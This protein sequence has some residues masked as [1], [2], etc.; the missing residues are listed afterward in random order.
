M[1]GP[2][3]LDATMVQNSRQTSF[4]VLGPQDQE[5]QA[6]ARAPAPLRDAK[7]FQQRGAAGRG[8]MRI[9]YLQASV[10]SARIADR[11]AHCPLGADLV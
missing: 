2:K 6:A 5:A 8:G 4:M 11:C 10:A 7:H 1:I 3:T 9:R